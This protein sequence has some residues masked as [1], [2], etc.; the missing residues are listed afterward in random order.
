[1]TDT[2]FAS[3]LKRPALLVLVALAVFFVVDRAADG[4]LRHGLDRYFGLDQ[5]E[6]VVMVGHSHVVLGLDKSQLE[7]DLG[8]P[9]ANYARAGAQ[10]EDRI[11]MARHYAELHPDGVRGI[12]FGVDHHLFTARGLSSNSHLLFYPH[13][14]DPLVGN[15]LHQRA[16]DDWEIAV[17]RIS[18]LARYNDVL[19]NAS[20]RGWLGN[21]DNAVVGRF[22]PET[23]AARVAAGN[24][25]RIVINPDQVAALEAFLAES[26]EQG[27]P[28]FLTFVPTTAQ[29]QAIEPDKAAEVDALLQ[30]L[31][32]RHDNVTFIDLRDPWSER[33]E[34]FIDPIHLNA[35]GSREVTADLYAK[36]APLLD[37]GPQEQPE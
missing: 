4:V 29:W 23:L 34:F 31:A 16:S 12:I 8:V 13:M 11:L 19:L 18:H 15:L 26:E 36:I 35:A 33:T 27:W 21:W 28:V 5:P 20:I 30:G 3:R 2:S 10:L 6:A 1:M 32:D 25:R 7:R 9:V 24:Y 37:A 22:N 14:D 17:R